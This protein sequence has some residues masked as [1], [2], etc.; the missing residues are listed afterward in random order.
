MATQSIGIDEL[1][2]TCRGSKLRVNHEVSWCVGIQIE[3]DP[4]IPECRHSRQGRGAKVNHLLS[5]VYKGFGWHGEIMLVPKREIQ[6]NIPV[7]SH[8]VGQAAW[9]EASLL[10]V[11]IIFMAWSREEDLGRRGLLAVAAGG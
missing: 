5:G 8:R 9:W 11:G 2:F 3:S 10:F 1:G 6:L 4:R 7:N